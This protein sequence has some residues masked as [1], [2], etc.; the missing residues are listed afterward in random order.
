ML[1][2][3][4]RNYSKIGDNSDNKKIRVT[5]FFM[6]KSDIKIQNNGIHCSHR[7]DSNE[8]TQHTVI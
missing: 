1:F 4:K 8:G 3:L 6:R 5:Y 2:Y 7:G